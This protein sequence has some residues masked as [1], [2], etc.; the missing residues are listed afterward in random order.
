MGTQMTK[1]KNIL[2]AVA[3]NAALGLEEKLTV[4]VVNN[5]VGT[6]QYFLRDNREAYPDLEFLEI[7]VGEQGLPYDEFR[8]RNVIM[9]LNFTP[10]QLKP[11]EEGYVFG[12]MEQTRATLG[13]IPFNIL[14]LHFGGDTAACHA[15]ND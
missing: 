2:E 9:F 3:A 13:T 14:S 4:V 7:R 6:A 11:M 12:R 15:K 1:Q 5:E 10:Y 8:D